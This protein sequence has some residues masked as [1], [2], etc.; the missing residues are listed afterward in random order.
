LQ[1][2]RV[3]P[4]LLLVFFALTG[5][6]SAAGT[7]AWSDSIRVQALG[8]DET[9]LQDVLNSL[10]Y[11]IDVNTDETGL[12]TF[13]TP[14]GYNLVDVKLISSG[15]SYT[16][17]LG[18]Y[19]AA[20]S[21][22]RNE[23]L[24]A[25]SSVGAIGQFTTADG[26]EFGLYLG[27]TLFDDIWYT[28]TALNWDA[29]DHA[30]IFQTSDPYVFVIAWEDLPVGGDQ[31]FQDV[32]AE[33]KFSNPTALDI[34]FTGDDYY[35]FCTEDFVC[36]DVNVTGGTGN[37]NL[38]LLEDG[39]PTLVANGASPLTYQYCFL[40]WPEDSV[41]TIAFSAEDDGGGSVEDSFS[42]EIRMNSRPELT[43][44]QH[45][46]DT[47]ICDLDSICFDV[48]S[49]SDV[50]SDQITFSLVSGEGSID[51]ITGEICFLPDDLDSAGYM[52]VVQASDSCC[53][54]LYKPLTPTGCPRDT[55][56]VNVRKAPTTVISTIEDTTIYLCELQEICFP[57]TATTGGEPVPVSQDCGGGTLDAGQLCFTPT[58]AGEYQFCFYVD[59]LCGT[60]RDTVNV[61]I[62]L[63]RP[64]VAD[65]GPDTLLH[66]N[67]GEVC[68]PAS[69]SDPDDNLVSCELVDG[70]GTYNGSEICFTP[71]SSDI[72]QF[73]LK[74]TDECEATDFDTVLVTIDAGNPPIAHV[75]DTT[76]A[77]CEPQEVCVAAF[78]E[79]PDADLVSC[80][81]I[82]APEGAQFDGSLACF[83]PQSS[84]T[85]L[86][87]LRAE[88]ACGSEDV[89]TG[90]VVL[91][92]NT[93][94]QVNPGG[95]NFD[96]CEP[97]SMCV[98][99][100]VYDPDGGYVVTSTMGEVTDNNTVCIYS[101][102]EPGSRQITF[103]IIATDTCGAA[104]TA[105]YV[106]NL[107]LN[108]PPE[109]TAPSLNPDTVCAGTQL[110]FQV[111]AVDTIMAGLL[112][113]LNSGEGTIDHQTGEVCFTVSTSG[114][115]T[116][117][118]EVTDSCGISDT[119]D[120][121]WSVTTYPEP[122]PVV[123]PPDG[124]TTFCYG[125]DPGE[126]C[127]DFTYD[128]NQAIDN[129]IVTP[130]ADDFSWTAD[131]SNGQGQICFTPLQDVSRSYGFTIDLTDICQQEVSTVYAHNVNFIDCDSS[132][133]LTL[134]I[135]QTECI[136]LSSVVNVDVILSEGM[137]PVGGYDLLIT[138]DVTAFSF[139]T[140]DI[141]SAINGW[142]Y[143]TFRL[144]PFSN[145]GGGCPS[146]M[147]RLVAIADINNGANH[148]PIDQFLPDG[149]VATMTFRATSDATFAGLV[150][151]VKFFWWDCGDNGIS[152][153]SGD[154]LLVDKRILDPEMLVW[155]EDDDVN[156]PEASRYVGVGVPD[157]CLEG[158]KNIPLRCVTFY[159][160][161]ICIIAN[162]SI[163][164]RGDINLNGLANEIADAVLFTNYFLRGLSVFTISIPAQTAASD[165]NNDGLTMSIG[166]L[167]YLIRIV[168]G[169]ALPIPK[170]SPYGEDAVLSLEQSG[171]STS[172]YSD[173]AS[174]LGGVFLKIDL[175]NATSYDVIKSVRAQD[176]DLVYEVEDGVMNLLVYGKERGAKIPAG[177]AKLFDF[178][179]DSDFRILHAEASDYYGNMVDLKIEKAALPV[180][181]ELGQNYPN[182]FNPE[183]EISMYL[184][185]QSDWS[186]TV[187][188][189]SGQVVKR[190]EGSS[191]A[192]VVTVTWD[193]TD[194]DGRPVAT[195]I[196]L[197]RM[198]AGGFADTKKM[199]LLK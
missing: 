33:V 84:G 161:S 158:D 81:M 69:C 175:G 106:I 72:Y 98:P 38:Y 44:D 18:W 60:V 57:V 20:D 74:A 146:G 179:S 183:T 31:D 94:P 49:A 129:I 181:F 199:L 118:V 78:C 125:D 42:V 172:V 93:P 65:A 115:H 97:D 131:F 121:Q 186:L 55:V 113:D 198:D 108:M 109:I 139:L 177:K 37:I 162:D 88:D 142:E 3:L 95:G 173:A 182:P 28:E 16:S 122:T 75:D 82:S 53:A 165:V 194:Q 180:G 43:V 126:I 87:I 107:R 147:I 73:V 168:T 85:Y 178:V 27:L 153:V 48:L 2:R 54:S 155:D 64:P 89:D 117:Q 160:G 80:E 105:Q 157:S 185:H 4:C 51:P 68:W 5:Y 184:S 171:S 190:F 103:D 61:T 167:I 66:C 156:F 39:T 101:G 41:Y 127:V 8:S 102:T 140:A 176:V 187:F 12:S 191:P 63:N 195:G 99:V 189:I 188:N 62:E 110:C 22:S 32:V 150:Y 36:F 79:D 47:T 90:S 24:P 56:I 149:V 52:F 34:S 114:V 137:I 17:P 133:C 35:L 29:F 120:V 30:K 76:L 143:F 104:D 10:G 119:A 1:V 83:T 40:P 174:D 25:G 45:V 21:A 92:L 193:G 124:D 14:P 154:T 86:F 144:G 134:S 46:I 9:S 112:F 169:D 135:E 70:P 116:W 192:G 163:D 15:S 91:T 164:T 96:L 145:C 23:L 77:L 148:P 100:N 128:D 26:Y 197:Y 71:P 151:P 58:G 196:Y 159:N 138:Y 141:G 123:A 67:T 132:E 166:D 7:F 170:L 111:S 50:D 136:T 13:T 19:P 11:S 130:N 6:A 152:T 59:D